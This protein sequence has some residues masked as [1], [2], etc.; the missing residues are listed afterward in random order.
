MPLL[1]TLVPT[2]F[3]GSPGEVA[4]SFCFAKLIYSV[5]KCLYDIFCVPSTVLGAWDTPVSKA[6]KD[7]CS[8]GEG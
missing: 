1:R 2:W 7:L 8:V 4:G 5:N 3:A 6:E